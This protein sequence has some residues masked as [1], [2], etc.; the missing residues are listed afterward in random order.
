MSFVIDR[1]LYTAEATVEGEEVPV[2]RGHVGGPTND[3]RIALCAESL[4]AE[5][6]G[7]LQPLDVRCVDLRQQAVA[8]TVERPVYGGPVDVFALLSVAACS[9]K[10]RDR[11]DCHGGDRG[12]SHQHPP[13]APSTVRVH[14]VLLWKSWK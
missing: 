3:D 11:C 2:G 8:L 7:D 13:T 4:R 12:G 5:L 9:S 10:R 14:F 6:P 1:I